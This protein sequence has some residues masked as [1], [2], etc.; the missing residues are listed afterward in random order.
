MFDVQA[1]VLE[2]VA[3]KIC[4]KSIL[5]NSFHSLLIYPLMAFTDKLVS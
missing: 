1:V 2:V 4:N 3:A 5:K